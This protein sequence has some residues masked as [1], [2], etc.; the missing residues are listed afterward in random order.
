MLDDEE[1]HH[2]KAMFMELMTPGKIAKLISLVDEQW[3][4]AIPRWAKCK[5]ITIFRDAQN[6]LCRAVCAWA[7]VPL[8]ESEV[9]QRAGEMGDLVYSFGVIHHSPRPRRILAE[10]RRHFVGPGTTMKLMLYHRRSLKVLGILFREAHGAWWRLDEAIADTRAAIL[11][12]PKLPQAHFNLGIFLTAKGDTDGAIRH[13]RVAVSLDPNMSNA[14]FNL[15]CLL[16]STGRPDEAEE[17][18]LAVLRRTPS[19]AN[20][21]YNLGVLLTGRGRFA[22]AARHCTEAFRLDP[23]MNNQTACRRD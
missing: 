2:R 11:L 7:G 8:Q 15:A 23:A 16:Q 3:Q 5:E 20:A 9:L 14:R 10:I 17:Q 12:N 19:A 22:E 6:I 4:H 13:T 18:Y 21:H 1:H